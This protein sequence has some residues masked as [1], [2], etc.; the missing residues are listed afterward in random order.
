MEECL[1]QGS[2]LPVAPPASRR[3]VGGGKTGE[4]SQRGSEF[5]A[6]VCALLLVSGC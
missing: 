6:C 1:V 5:I 3:V 2:R 4:Q